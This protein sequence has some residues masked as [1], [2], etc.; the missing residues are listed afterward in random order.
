MSVQLLVAGGGIGGLASA[1]ALARKGH[2][3]ELLEQASHFGEVGA[4]IQLGPNATRRLDGLGL[5]P[6]LQ[7]IAAQP[8]ALVIRSASDD[9]ELARLP[10]GSAMQQRYGAPYLCVHRADLHGLLLDAVRDSDRVVLHT[11]ARLAHVSARGDAVCVSTV[12][13]RAWEA[14]GLVGADGLWSRVRSKVIDGAAPRATGHTAWR[15]LIAQDSLP[16]ALRSRQVR[17]WLGERLHAVSYPVR[18]GD[19]LNVVVLAE[20]APS[21]DARDWNQDTSLGALRTATGRCGPGLQALLETMP[22]WRAWTLSD[23][24]PLAGPHQMVDDRIALL[25]DAAHPML[26][27]LAQGAGMAI[28]D[29]VALADALAGGNAATVPAA[30]QAYAAARWQRNARVQARAHR[31]G[32]IFHAGGLVRWGRDAGLRLLGPTLLD[33]PWL[34]AG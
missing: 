22:D 30:F 16:A 23:R 15:S 32:R 34:Y 9:A 12:D 11:G 19:A 29:A 25:G 21:G 26:P 24:P 13:A 28:E 17:V 14:D 3:I 1:L 8:E 18:G 20:A 4:G 2:A 7:A 31:N 6:A 10:L 33:V 5:L 27:Y